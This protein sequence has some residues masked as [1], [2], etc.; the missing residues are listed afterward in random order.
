MTGEFVGV[1]LVTAIE[2]LGSQPYGAGN[3]RMVGI[4]LQRG[5]Q[6]LG[7]AFVLVWAFWLNT[8]SLLLL[9]RKKWLGRLLACQ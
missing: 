5:V 3:F 2:V 4:V 7:V 9:K 6:M 1:G 8:D